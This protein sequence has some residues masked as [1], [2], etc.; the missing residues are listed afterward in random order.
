MPSTGDILVLRIAHKR[1]P[2]LILLSLGGQH[3]SWLGRAKSF[4]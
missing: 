3:P 1:L 4:T 2:T